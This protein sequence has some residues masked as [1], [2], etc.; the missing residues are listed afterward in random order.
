MTLEGDEPRITINGVELSRAQA[1]TLRVTLT[2]SLANLSDEDAL[3]DDEVGRSL[4]SAYRSRMREIIQLML[5]G[6]P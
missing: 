2:S 3:G 5:G 1:M 6:G 4:A